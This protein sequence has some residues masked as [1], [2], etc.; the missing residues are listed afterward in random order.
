MA[1]KQGCGCLVFV[2]IGLVAALIMLEIF[3]PTTRQRGPTAPFS[4]NS[5]FAIERIGWTFRGSRNDYSWYF[6][7]RNKTD[8]M[9]EC[10][11]DVALMDGSDRVGGDP[12][13]FTV[14]A[15]SVGEVRNDSGFT[16]YEGA[17]AKIGIVTVGCSTSKSLLLDLD[18]DPPPPGV[19]RVVTQR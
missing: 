1:Q 3:A 12:D 15:K 6:T 19:L 9:L 18:A 8:H 4:E 7:V 11:S 17:D 5:D 10:H 16:P 14:A 2:G 13:S